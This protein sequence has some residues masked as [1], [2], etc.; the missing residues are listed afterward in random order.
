MA[1]VKAK[2]TES[3][4]RDS[5]TEENLANFRFAIVTDL[6]FPPDELLD[7]MCSAIIE[8][9]SQNDDEEETFEV[10]Q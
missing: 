4:Q 8:D 7:R 1:L 9:S 2:D 3:F 6:E 5:F 10:L